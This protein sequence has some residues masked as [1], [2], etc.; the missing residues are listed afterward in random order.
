MIYQV[1]QLMKTDI[2]TSCSMFKVGH[3]IS[4]NKQLSIILKQDKLKS[5]ITKATKTYS[6]GGVL[7]TLDELYA[8][9]VN[10]NTQVGGA[11]EVRDGLAKDKE[12]NQQL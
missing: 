8:E 4:I 12:N 2:N 11:E 6:D 3:I 10:K 1:L 7:V 9:T 5:F